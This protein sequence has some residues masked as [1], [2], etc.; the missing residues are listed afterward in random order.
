MDRPRESLSGCTNVC[1]S[2]AGSSA[3]L[4]FGHASCSAGQCRLW[5][6]TNHSAVHLQ[7]A[8]LA[9]GWRHSYTADL[10]KCWPIQPSS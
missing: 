2:L 3:D 5:Q 9:C 7:V 6:T 4:D 8:C 1:I 10:C